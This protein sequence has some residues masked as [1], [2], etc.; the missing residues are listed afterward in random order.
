MTLRN[1]I[2]KKKKL[3]IKKSHPTWLI[4]QFL[5]SIEHLESLPKI[6]YTVLDFHPT[7]RTMYIGDI[8]NTSVFPPKKFP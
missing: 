3:S 5:I 7:Q 2:A 6:I 1:L 8:D 4:K